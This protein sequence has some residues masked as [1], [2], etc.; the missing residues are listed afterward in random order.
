[1]EG[2]R[3]GRREGGSSVGSATISV[4]SGSVASYLIYADVRLHMS[5]THQ[6]LKVPLI[7]QLAANPAANDTSLRPSDHPLVFKLA[8]QS[9]IVNNEWCEHVF[10]SLLRFY[11]FV[12][13]HRRRQ[14]KDVAPLMCSLEPAKSYSIHVDIQSSVISSRGCAIPMF[15][16]V[17]T[18]ER[19]R[20]NPNK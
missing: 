10:P 16:I 4:L 18:R 11:Y 12:R 6:S 19:A 17:L 9:K 7:N 20:A 5:M 2:G 3:E 15:N 1:M 13:R 8:G 14:K